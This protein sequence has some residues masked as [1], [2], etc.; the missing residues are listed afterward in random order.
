MTGVDFSDQAIVLARS[1]AQEA[2]L[3]AQFICTNVYD[4][5][6]AEIRPQTFDIVY[7]A[8]GVLG[9]LPDLYQW[10]EII[11]DLLMPGGTFYLAEVHPLL[12]ILDQQA[13]QIQVV[14]PYFV[15]EPL[16]F[17]YEHSYV[18]ASTKLTHTVEYEWRHSM[19][20][21]LNALLA[22][23]LKLD[24]L[25]EFPF[26]AWACFPDMERGQDGWWRFR[27]KNKEQ[28]LPLFFSLKATKENKK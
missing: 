20:T 1:L 24:F 2:G 7:M 25:H 10:A 27:D 3:D 11:A 14:F 9:W 15:S 28:L 22:G 23:G 12:R 21:I 13:G 8:R 4:L 6:K 26:C 5:P 16:R 19:S 17:E 18:D